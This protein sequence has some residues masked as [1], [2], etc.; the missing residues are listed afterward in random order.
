MCFCTF[1]LSPL[2]LI[3]TTRT[4]HLKRKN[5]GIWVQILN[6]R[7]SCSNIKS[8][9]KH[10][11]QRFRYQRASK[12]HTSLYF[13]RF[14]PWSSIPCFNCGMHAWIMKSMKRL[15]KSNIKPAS[16]N[17]GMEKRIGMLVRNKV[18]A[19]ICIELIFQQIA[20]LFY[21]KILFYDFPSFH[22]LQFA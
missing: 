3:V 17:N 10:H 18:C 2:L 20:F 21:L 16:T 19:Y 6:H 11:H 13:P 22:Y 7:L 14:E 8:V 1:G 12:P 15:S 9:Y 4:D 5:A